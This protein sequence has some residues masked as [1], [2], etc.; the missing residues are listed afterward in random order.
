MVR[1]VQL[2]VQLAIT[3]A[4]LFWRF[5]SH[6]IFFNSEPFYVCYQDVRTFM[7]MSEPY[8]SYVIAELPFCGNLYSCFFL[9][10]FFFC[11]CLSCSLFII[12]QI[13]LHICLLH[14]SLLPFHY[15]SFPFQLPM[16]WSFSP[17][18]WSSSTPNHFG[19]GQQCLK[20]GVAKGGR[21]HHLHKCLW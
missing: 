19:V 15:F 21:S 3:D 18:I 8:L 13:L 2:W 9:T 6:Q 1:S 20:D 7:K 4:L 16:F 14:L 5:L 17:S 12:L 10:S 11:R